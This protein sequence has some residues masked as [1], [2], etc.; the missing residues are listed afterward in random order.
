M[1][2]SPTYPGVYVQEV[3]SGVRTIVGVSTSI[4][5]F[6]GRTRTGALND[7]IRLTN[8]T[9]FVREFGEDNT[10]SDMARYVKLFFLNGGSDCYVM[11]IAAGALPAAVDLQN[12]A[13]DAVLTL[14]AKSPGRRGN[15]IRA[16]VSY[17]GQY[18]EATFNLEV[19]RS[20]TDSAGNKVK[21][22][23]EDWK[24]LSMDPA[25]STYAPT[26]LSQKSALVNAREAST[27]PP[28]PG[29]SIS[30]RP[31]QQ[32]DNTDA[33]FVDAWQA[34]LGTGPDARHRFQISVD[35]SRYVE[36]ELRDPDNPADP[37]DVG[38]LS[39]PKR[40]ALAAAIAKRI[41]TELAEA[42]VVLAND[43]VVTIEDG[44]ATATTGASTSYLKVA[45]GGTGDSAGDVRILSSSV[46]AD[47]LAVLLML[48]EANGGT[49]VS[50]HSR[51]RPAPTGLSL[52]ANDLD[53][54][55]GFAGLA[56]DKIERIVLTELDAA[57]N[58]VAT[59]GG[60]IALDLETTGSATALMWNDATS[61]D[62]AISVRGVREKLGII[63][64]AIN[65][66]QANHSSRF[67]W[68]AELWGSRLAILPTA[69]DDNA[70]IPASIFATAPTDL[71]GLTSEPFTANVRYYS[72]GLNALGGLQGNGTAGDDGAAPEA[73]DYDKAY[74]IA[75][76]EIDLFNLLVLPPDNAATATPLEQLWPAASVFAQQRR[77]FLIMDP[78]DDWDS[79]QEA[80][81]GV[82]ALRVGLVKDYAAIYFPRLRVLENGITVPLGPAGAMAGLYARIDANRG[83]WKAPAG[84][85]ADLRAVSGVTL[86]MSDA[87]NGQINPVGVN[88]IRIFPDGV[89][90]WGARTMAGADAFAS[91]YKYVPVRRLALFI[92]E[93]LYRGLKWVVFEPNDD[94][95]YG[96]IRLNVG[97]FMHD[98][99]RKGAF[100]GLKPAEAF[101]V[102]CDR[103]TTTQND[104]NRGI[105]NIW[106]GFAPL[107][108]AEFVILYLQQM[109]GQVEAA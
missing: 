78:P 36:V 44:P 15:A 51:R 94:D 85:E 22:D 8:Y 40:A 58:E 106:V 23:R 98:L 65:A 74:V 55:N 7:P 88:A 61:A 57:G 54:M 12:E 100:F 103:E 56:Q 46:A 52:R 30:G 66:Y 17:N 11:R 50:A 105:V 60:A 90:S 35:G 107:R 80:F 31:V 91:E 10:V 29:F 16:A 95:L 75:D 97:A 24:N 41:Q 45:S 109:A 73:A 1:A 4:T 43:A 64:D 5:L 39:G 68:K 53:V 2:V 6:I 81:T 20:V 33:T 3:P 25:A 27:V 59:P 26:F 42:G 89:V 101:F 82:D 102:K 93:S 19:F 96:Q 14:E 84:T 76:A 38:A 48:G 71:V 32:D 87:E 49:E 77:A 13:G 69:G 92:E 18:P 83:V 86:R 104:R 62:P 70:I 79:S 47:D 108:P 21:A 99:F 63:R 9:D 37:L 28:V 72:L 34:L 67:F